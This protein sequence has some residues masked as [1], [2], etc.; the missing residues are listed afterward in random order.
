VSEG[1]FRGA[2]FTGDKVSDV[3]QLMNNVKKKKLNKSKQKYRNASD[4]KMKQQ[5]YRC[6]KQKTTK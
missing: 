5:M 2:C 6:L 1:D 3:L 4:G